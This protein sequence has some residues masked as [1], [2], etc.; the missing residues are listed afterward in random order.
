[1]STILIP[2]IDI[3]F[4]KKI[5]SQMRNQQVVSFLDLSLWFTFSILPKSV[6]TC[7]PPV[8]RLSV[9]RLVLHCHVSGRERC[10][11]SEVKRGHLEAQRS[12][13]AAR[14]FTGS[15]LEQYKLPADWPGRVPGVPAQMEWSQFQCQFQTKYSL[16]GQYFPPFL[17]TDQSIHFHRIFLK[18]SSLFTCSSCSF[19]SVP[20]LSLTLPAFCSAPALGCNM[21]NCPGL[22]CVAS[23]LTGSWLIS[24]AG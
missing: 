10:F 17:T 3:L 2:F 8:A 6:W 1:M 9:L 16:N 21:A 13:H 7:G 20:S 24:N 11:R 19:L 18:Y 12:R 22:R 23:P 14:N 15:S 5:K 4:I